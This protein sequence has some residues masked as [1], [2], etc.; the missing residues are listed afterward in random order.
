MVEVYSGMYCHHTLI[1]F[2]LIF[3]RF[4]C[5][6]ASLIPLE[7]S[8]FQKVCHLWRW[9]LVTDSVFTF[10]TWSSVMNP[11]KPWFVV[12]FYCIDLMTCIKHCSA[13]SF[14]ESDVHMCN[15]ETHYLKYLCSVY[16]PGDWSSAQHCFKCANM[17]WRVGFY[18]GLHIFLLCT[19]L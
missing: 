5:L 18:P 19:F 16:E 3:S 14:I 1:Q 10:P 17:W 13:K 8:W 11:R 15:V 9:C 7:H 6:H 12:Y 2:I 4:R